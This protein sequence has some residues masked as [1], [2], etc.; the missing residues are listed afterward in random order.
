[1]ERFKIL[2]VMID[3]DPSV[4]DAVAPSLLLF[5]SPGSLVKMFVLTLI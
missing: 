4:V 1:M 3:G 5:A 2:G